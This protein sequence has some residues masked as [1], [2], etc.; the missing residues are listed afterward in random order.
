[1]SERDEWV[2]AACALAAA[3]VVWLAGGAVTPP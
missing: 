2:L 3:L 1:M